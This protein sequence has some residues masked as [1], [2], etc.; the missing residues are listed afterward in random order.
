MSYVDKDTD[1][2]KGII[3]V[4]ERENLANGNGRISSEDDLIFVLSLINN[5]LCTLNN[6]MQRIADSC[7]TGINVNTKME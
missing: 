2:A 3:T 5:N 1:G 6:T 7:N 4:A